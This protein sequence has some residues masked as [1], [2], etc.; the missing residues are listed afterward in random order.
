M[1]RKP[2]TPAPPVIRHRPVKRYT[3]APETIDRIS[4]I[5]AARTELRSDSA[6]IDWAVRV[7]TEAGR[8]SP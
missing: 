3:L 5:R 4:A 7:A 6:V 2:N 1:P 8:A